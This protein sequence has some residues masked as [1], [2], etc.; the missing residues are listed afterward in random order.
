MYTPENDAFITPPLKGNPVE[1]PKPLQR[2]KRYEQR[3][4][5]ERSVSFRD[6]VQEIHKMVAASEEWTRFWQAGRERA[7]GPGGAAPSC[8]VWPDGTAWPPGPLP[9]PHLLMPPSLLEVQA[10]EGRRSLY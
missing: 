6:V 10:L 1:I 9:P 4:F 2:V 5:S 7:R 8:G 3:T